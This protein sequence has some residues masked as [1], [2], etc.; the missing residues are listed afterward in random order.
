MKFYK[1][2]KDM[3]D[4][5]IVTPKRREDPRIV[6][7]YRSYKRDLKEDFKNCCGYCGDEDSR[8]GGIRVFQIDHFV[9]KKVMVN[10]SETE[11]S[12]L[13]YSCFYCNNKKRADWPTGDEDIHYNG[14]KGY[15]DP[16]HDDFPL[17]FKR[18]SLGEIV[19]L[20]QI[21]SYMHSK[22]N[23]R[24]RRHALIWHLSRLS[25]KIS[26]LIKLKDLGYLDD[27]LDEFTTILIQYFQ[28]N[29][30]LGIANNE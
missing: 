28:Y 30:Q 15:I 13:V 29:E 20:T 12:N 22:L 2:W 4:F 19:P 17:Q 25:S 23:F 6:S 7:H 9:P 8:A 26:E 18:N 24:L 27:E 3:T 11:Y 10:L 1:I 14:N 21:G 5:R 16:C